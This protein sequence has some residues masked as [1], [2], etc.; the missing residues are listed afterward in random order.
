[1]RRDVDEPQPISDTLFQ[2]DWTGLTVTIEQERSVVG[3]PPDADEHDPIPF[4]IEC[5]TGL[6][7]DD[8]TIQSGAELANIID[9]TRP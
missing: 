6:E 3:R 4:R 5:L 7:H 8:R 2:F 1:M 9:T